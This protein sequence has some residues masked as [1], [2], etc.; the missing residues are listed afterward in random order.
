MK[1]GRRRRMDPSASGKYRRVGEVLP[2]SARDLLHLSEEGD[3]YGNAVAIP[4]IHAAIAYADS[5]CIA[6]GEFKSTEGDHQGAVKAV[7]EAVGPAADAGAIRALGIILSEK[8]QVSYQGNYYTLED[9]AA[10][11]RRLETFVAWAEQVLARRA[12]SS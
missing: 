1:G 4:A 9:A 8:D 7:K 3:T 6:F 12:L 11:V 10:V 5:I 2:G